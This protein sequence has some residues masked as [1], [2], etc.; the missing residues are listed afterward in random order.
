[1]HSKP[2][3]EP[4][5]PGDVGRWDGVRIGV[6]ARRLGRA[7]SGKAGAG[8]GDLRPAGSQGTSGATC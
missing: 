3:E 8:C 4:P 5:H 2:K 1:M 6:P 7:V